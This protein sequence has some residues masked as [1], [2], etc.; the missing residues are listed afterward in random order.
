[1]TFAYQVFNG[2]DV[3]VLD[4]ISVE[5]LGCQVALTIV[6]AERAIKRSLSLEPSLAAG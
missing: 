5:L 2:A 3:C 1:M 4:R 6:A